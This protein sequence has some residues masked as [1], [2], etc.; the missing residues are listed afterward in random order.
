MQQLPENQPAPCQIGILGGGQLAHMTIEAARKLDESIRV[1]VWVDQD[2]SPAV[3][4][5]DCV[6]RGRF[7]DE[8]N[9]ALFAGYAQTAVVE[10]E[11]IPVMTL[12]ELAR[13]GVEVSPLPPMLE[14]A[15]DRLREKQLACELGIPRVPFMPVAKLA[16]AER[17]DSLQK[18]AHCTPGI[19]K[20]RWGGYDGKGQKHVA[21]V[22]Q[23]P[24]AFAEFGGA[25]CELE[26]QLRLKQ[27]VS[28]IG[29]RDRE[30][31]KA[32]YPAIENFHDNGILTRSVYHTCD[33]VSI[34]V[35]T[36][37]LEY[38]GRI[39]DKM[40]HWGI[41]V[42]EFFVTEDKPGEEK[43]YLNEIAPRPHN[44]GHLTIEGFETSQFEQLV[45]ILMGMPLG[46]VE[47]HGRSVEMVN[48]IGSAIHK[49]E[50]YRE[51]GFVVHRYGKSERPGRKLGHVT[52][53]HS[54]Q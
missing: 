39:L 32:L 8:T 42:A 37:A 7:D 28:V 9:A 48:L 1:A 12:I 17:S 26:K 22:L 29:V 13:L 49:A 31:N 33:S 19:L 14:V 15:Q 54:F 16:C 24:A 46:S 30:G 53:V 50:A 41:L 51:R 25:Y 35:R 18:Y 4:H 10:T 34:A 11:N 6:L 38:T 43:V 20:T 44:S 40:G 27:E 3:D 5:A 45:R 23:L 47:P 2:E 36:L 52:R 21:E